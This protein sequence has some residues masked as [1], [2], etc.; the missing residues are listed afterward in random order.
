MPREV[1]PKAD[2]EDDMSGQGRRHDK[3]A[4][5]NSFRVFVAP[6]FV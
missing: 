1:Q 5:E 3:D 6:N 4:A 2:A